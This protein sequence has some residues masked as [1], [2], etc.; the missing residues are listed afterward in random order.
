M[1]TLEPRGF[2]P[3][4]TATQECFGG[5]LDKAYRAKVYYASNGALAATKTYDRKKGYGRLSWVRF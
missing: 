1:A 2:H 3:R 4:Y 5:K